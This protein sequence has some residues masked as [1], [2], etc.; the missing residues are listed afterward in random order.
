[1][2]SHDVSNKAFYYFLKFIDCI[3]LKFCGEVCIQT[4]TKQKKTYVLIYFLEILAISNSLGLRCG[5]YKQLIQLT[6]IQI[7]GAKCVNHITK[8]G[9]ST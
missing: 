7:N 3:L 1:M 2:P 5:K 8:R 9:F 6:V 4:W